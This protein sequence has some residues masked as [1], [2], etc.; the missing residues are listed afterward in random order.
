M[1]KAHKR[2]LVPKDPNQPI[3]DTFESDYQEKIGL[4]NERIMEAWTC[5]LDTN[6]FNCQLAF[7]LFNQCVMQYEITSAVR[8]QKPYVITTSDLE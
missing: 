1:L 8:A 6:G 4:L 5:Y 3:I 2:G 7:R